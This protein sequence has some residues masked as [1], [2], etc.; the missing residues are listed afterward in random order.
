MRG[1]IAAGMGITSMILL[2]CLILIGAIV[3]YVLIQ[4]QDQQQEDSLNTAN[5]AKREVTTQIQLL[6]LSATDGRDGS[7]DEF[8]YSIRLKPGADAIKL[9]DVVLYMNTY[10][11]TLRLVYRKG[12]TRRDA[13]NGFFTYR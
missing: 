7:L 8:R 4:N 5:A 10:N 1:K 6:D 3:A 9:S 13:Q 2:I 11:D 12:G